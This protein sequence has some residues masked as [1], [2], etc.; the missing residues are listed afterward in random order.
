MFEDDMEFIE[1]YSQVPPLPPRYRFRDLIWGE[2]SHHGQNDDRLVI[3]MVKSAVSI[4]YC[5]QIIF[6]L[7]I[8]C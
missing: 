1:S 5:I 2:S 4:I 6:S 3:N 8:Q 7:A